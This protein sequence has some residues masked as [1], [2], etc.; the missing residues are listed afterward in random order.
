MG[1]EVDVGF[2]H[3]VLCS[4][5][6]EVLEEANLLVVTCQDAVGKQVSLLSEVSLGN[7][8]GSKGIYLFDQVLIKINFKVLSCLDH[9]INLLN[10]FPDILIVIV[11]MFLFQKCFDLQL[12]LQLNVQIFSLLSEFNSYIDSFAFLESL[13]KLM[14]IICIDGFDQVV[15]VTLDLL[16]NLL[17]S[18]DWS[19]RSFTIPVFIYKLRYGTLLAEVFVTLTA[20][21][22]N[23]F[24]IE[25]GSARRILTIF[26]L[27][28]L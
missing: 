24:E 26:G 1:S 10:I 21:I 23:V 8:P 16:F 17:G 28:G 27:C 12:I 5:V 19:F 22:S 13:I 9:I 18:A 3:L 15:L 2:F 25:L 11:M 14:V 4:V 20:I 7:E 6:D